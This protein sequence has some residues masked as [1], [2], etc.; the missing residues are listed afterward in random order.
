LQSNALFFWGIKGR[1]YSGRESR[2]ERGLE[3][4]QKRVAIRIQPAARFDR[5]ER[6]GAGGGSPILCFIASMNARTFGEG[7]RVDG[8]TA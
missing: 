6:T 3:A 4:G 5:V 8:Y 7:S 2:G 1:I